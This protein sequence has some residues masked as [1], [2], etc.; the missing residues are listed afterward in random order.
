MVPSEPSVQPAQFVKFGVLLRHLRLR[1][2]LTLRDLSITVGYS[3]GYLSRLEQS[4]RR[5][6]RAVV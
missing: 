4:Q 6:N 1:V 5:P 2:Q 3:E